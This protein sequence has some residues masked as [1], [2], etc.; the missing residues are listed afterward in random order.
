MAVSAIQK[1]TNE[2]RH[3]QSFLKSAA[4]GAFFGYALKWA[5]P[6]MPQEK[7]DVFFS[8]IEKVKKQAQQVG[9]NEFEV[10]KTANPKAD[11]TDEF[12]RLF[13]NNKED[14]FKKK[15]F[16]NHPA[17]NVMRLYK[18]VLNLVQ[19]TKYKGYDDLA[20]SVKRIRSTSAFIIIGFSIG[21]ASA[22]VHNIKVSLAKKDREV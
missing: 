3:R 17:E 9:L 21:L 11:G 19:D 4:T 13:E 12:V 8:E 7:D 10:I 6:V 2:T 1:K 18:R 15:K 5:I 20:H 22:M 14:L 16:E